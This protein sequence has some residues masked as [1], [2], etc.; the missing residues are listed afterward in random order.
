[1]KLYTG[2]T[3]PFGARITIA[4]R[5]KGVVIE[6][7]R[8]PAG[9]IKS[10]EYLAINPVGKIPALITESGAAIPESEAILAY[11][12]DRFPTPSLRPS[13]P[14]Q[15]AR[16]NVAIR[17]MDTYVMA[18]VIRLFPHLDRTKRDERTVEQEVA[19]WKD[20]L[21]ALAHFMKLPMPS[22]EAGVSMA[23]C[24]LPPSIHLSARISM[25][26]ELGEDLL[27]PHGVLVD[28][29]ARM[30]VHPVVGPI[31]ADLTAAQ[32]SYDVS[33]GRPSLAARH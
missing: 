28:Y 7:L 30:K 6:N 13:D 32:A 26:L 23:D 18:P 31:L 8:L 25:M 19:R 4:A 22:A 3:S 21:E 24:V 12:E 14:E 1:M 33:H 17:I 20:G 10:P 15:R 16:V 11:L 9:G 29:Y 27:K 5:A 2:A